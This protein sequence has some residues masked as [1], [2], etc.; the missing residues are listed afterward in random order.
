MRYGHAIAKRLR[1]LGH[2]VILTTREH[3]DTMNVMKT[4]GEHAKI[5]G[6]YDPASLATRF[7]ASIEREL[8]FYE[9][10]KDD[11][12]QVAISHGS[13]ELS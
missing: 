4:L 10:F 3:P 5:V 7:K 11:M 2:Q 1:K 12:P 8:Q 6:K 13:V 9:M